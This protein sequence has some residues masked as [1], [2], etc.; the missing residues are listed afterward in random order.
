MTEAQT[1]FSFPYPTEKQADL[2][3]A[4]VWLM[5]DG[6]A[7]SVL[8]IQNELGTRKEISARV[9]ELRRTEFGGW[10]FNDARRD[11]PDA[12]GV[13]RYRLDVDRVTGK[14]LD[15]LRGVAA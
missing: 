10:P 14:H 13:F 4:I 2:R 11:G 7:R 15:S 6:K 8:E 1:R 3:K 9:R 12:D 5:L